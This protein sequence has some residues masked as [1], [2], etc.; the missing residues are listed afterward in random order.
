[1]SISLVCL[2]HSH[3]EELGAV[4]SNA[5]PLANDLCG[6]DEVFKDF[7]VDAGEGAA[8]RPLLHNTGRAGGLAE[9]AALGDE[10]DVTVGKLLLELTG[11]PTPTTI[12]VFPKLLFHLVHKRT[13]AG[14]CGMPSTEG[15]ARR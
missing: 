6:E 8:A 12:L 10:N 4:N 14:S 11:K 13:S 3:F 7:F 5:G 15:Q 2:I 1:M 9:H